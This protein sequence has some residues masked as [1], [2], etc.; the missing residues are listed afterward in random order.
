MAN[1]FLSLFFVTGLLPVAE[2][3]TYIPYYL[4]S[5]LGDFLV[6]FSIDRTIIFNFYH[7][8]FSRLLLVQL[9]LV[10][11]CINYATTCM[12]RSF[13]LRLLR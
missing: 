11:I 2:K 4:L 9:P 12:F 8:Y 5:V 10:N 7:N 3:P 6:A 13:L 1:N